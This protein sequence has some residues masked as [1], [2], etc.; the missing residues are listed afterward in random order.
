ME[1]SRWKNILYTYKTSCIDFPKTKEH[2]TAERSSQR[3]MFGQPPP[4][5]MRLQE[6]FTWASDS[7]SC[8]ASKMF[9]DTS[10]PFIVALP[11]H[12]I[13]CLWRT[14][15]LLKHTCCKG[16]YNIWVVTLKSGYNSSFNI[17][18]NLARWGLKVSVLDPKHVLC[19]W[20]QAPSVWDCDGSPKAEAIMEIGRNF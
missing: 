9:K 8:K 20:S 4:P 19:T 3:A 15:N 5:C 10:G 2:C 6:S 1:W 17:F 14:Q 7:S 12:G 11:W 13:G 18:F 16:L